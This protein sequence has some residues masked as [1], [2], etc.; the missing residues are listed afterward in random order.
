MRPKVLETHLTRRET[1]R[2][3]GGLGL[4]VAAAGCGSDDGSGGAT[5]PPLS[6]VLTPEQIQGPYFLD[7]GLRRRDI[8]EGRPGVPLLLQLRL[9]SVVEGVCLPLRGAA[10][11][12]WH[13]DADGVYS[14]YDVSDGNL[15]DAAGETFLR[16]HQVSDESG[17]VELETIYPGWY[18]GRAVHI[19]LMVL[20]DDAH[21]LTTQLYFPDSVSDVVQ[22]EQPYAA[23]GPRDTPNTRDLLAGSNLDALTCEIAPDRDGYVARLSLGVAL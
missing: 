17:I 1:L 21:R 9:A 2:A 11:E 22:A 6:C 14:G 13:A 15:R 19:H 3:I 18:P 8:T 7:T 23:R 5:E 4:V 16:G 20:V 12:A 10:V